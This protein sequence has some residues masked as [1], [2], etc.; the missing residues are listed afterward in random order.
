MIYNFAEIN[1][2]SEPDE[3]S[4]LLG[5]FGSANWTGQSRRVPQK[6][7][8][9]DW[10][11][12]GREVVLLHGNVKAA[13]SPERVMTVTS[14]QHSKSSAT[15]LAAINTHFLV[16]AY[17]NKNNASLRTYWNTAWDKLKNRVS[18][19]VSRG[20]D[21]VVTGD[22]NNHNLSMMDKIH[23]KARRVVKNGPDYLY[24]IPSGGRS[25]Q[26]TNKGVMNTPSGEAS[27]N[28]IWA[29]VK[30]SGGKT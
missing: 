22:F 12:T 20:H 5:V 6:S 21:V 24:V 10:K 7:D 18:H 13:P 29:T 19:L 23:S 15:K 9:K 28:N 14:Y 8:M 1:E 4:A 2:G 27:H 26:I 30:F 3:R 25:V 16:N 11:I 17:N